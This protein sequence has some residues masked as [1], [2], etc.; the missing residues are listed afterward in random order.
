MSYDDL[1]YCDHNC[2]LYDYMDTIESGE[3][4][5]HKKFQDLKPIQELENYKNKPITT[6]CKGHAYVFYDNCEVLHIF[7]SYC[8]EE[9]ISYASHL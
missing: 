2:G 8:F 6:C 9:A 5:S 7:F 3:S 4:C 1:D